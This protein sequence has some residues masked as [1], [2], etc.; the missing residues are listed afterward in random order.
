MKRYILIAYFFFWAMDTMAQ[1]TLTG[2]VKDVQGTPLFGAVV[3][4]VGSNNGAV[5][6]ESGTFSLVLPPGEHRSSIG[7]EVFKMTL[8]RYFLPSCLPLGRSSGSVA[9]CL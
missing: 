9:L 5:T 7:V 6:N 4:V 1:E 8:N 2:S 3:Q